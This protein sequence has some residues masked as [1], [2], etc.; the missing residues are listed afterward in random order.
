MLLALKCF[1]LRPFAALLVGF[2][3][4]GVDGSQLKDYTKAA[5]VAAA[6]ADTRVAVMAI[7]SLVSAG[8][9]EC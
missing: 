6:I 1:A 8:I 5:A 3:T 9:A 2:S 4:K 7:V